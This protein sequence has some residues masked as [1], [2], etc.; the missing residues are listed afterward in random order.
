MTIF[1]EGGF[2]PSP[3][4]PWAAPKRPILNRVN[5]WQIWSNCNM[6]FEMKSSWVILESSC[7]YF[8]HLKMHVFNRIA[9][10]K[11]ICQTHKKTPVSKDSLQQS[12]R[13]Y[14]F[15]WDFKKFFAQKILH[16]TCEKTDFNWPIFSRIKTES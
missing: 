5:L 10:L 12:C 9:V 15:P 8:R 13:P 1:R 2:L 16:K 6:K 4:H 3:R 14:I 7:V 11:K